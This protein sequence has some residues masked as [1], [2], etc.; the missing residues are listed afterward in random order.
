MDC[1]QRAQ[2]AVFGIIILDST[3]HAF[4]SE[5]IKRKINQSIL[6]TLAIILQSFNLY[7]R[8]SA[9]SK[10]SQATAEKRCQNNK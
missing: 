6:A 7:L 5:H 8:I 2:Q 1:E 9:M 10:L 3:R 4:V